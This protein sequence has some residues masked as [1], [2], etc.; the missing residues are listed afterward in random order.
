VIEQ[1]EAAGGE[2]G[3]VAE[4]SEPAP[5]APAEEAAAGDPPL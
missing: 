5:E 4:P 1:E 3:K 2:P